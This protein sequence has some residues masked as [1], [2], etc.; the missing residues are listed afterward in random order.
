M[1]VDIVSSSAVVR[2]G[3]GAQGENNVTIALKPKM[4]S[5]LGRAFN[6]MISEISTLE[7]WVF[8]EQLTAGGREQALQSQINPH[9]V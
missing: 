6:H 5:V 1:S 4:N 3:A 2:H 7:Q 9:F 8:R